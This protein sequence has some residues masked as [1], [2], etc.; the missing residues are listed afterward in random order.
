MPIIVATF[1]G[2]ED[3][4]APS[5]DGKIFRFPVTLIDRDDVGTPRQHSKTKSARVRVEFSD[6]RIQTWGL[7]DR[8]ALKVAFEIAKEELTN[9]LTSGKWSDGELRVVVTTDSHS[10]P[11]PFDPALS[12]EPAG[13]IVETEIKRRIGFI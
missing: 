13:A 3:V 7:T 5:Y 10:G 12:Q 6:S 8:E 4:T 2:P 11:C 9:A 1:A